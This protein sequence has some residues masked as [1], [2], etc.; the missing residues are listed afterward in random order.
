MPQKVGKNRLHFDLRPRE[1]TRDDEVERVL[2]MGATQ[3]ADHRGIHGPGSG[4]VVLADPPRRRTLRPPLG[5]RDVL[6][7]NLKA[8]D[9]LHEVSSAVLVHTK[10]ER[11]FQP[12]DAVSLSELREACCADG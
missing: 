5:R 11:S 8:L 3:V 9:D 1:G 4:W 7:T 12:P 10:G 2:A 6:V